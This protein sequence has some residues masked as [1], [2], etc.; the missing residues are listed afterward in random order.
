V[1]SFRSPFAFLLTAVAALAAAAPAP[2]DWLVTKDGA[3]IETKGA[4]K[5]QGRQVVFTM[6][7]GTLSAL[8]AE[9]VDLDRSA[10]VTAQAAEAAV[11]VEEPAPEVARRAPVMTL[12]ERDIPPSA[13]PEMPADFAP[14]A[15]AGGEAGEAGEAGEE[16]AAESAP[17]TSSDLE[18]LSWDKAPTTSGDGLQI[19]GTLKNSGNSTITS[20][21][22][23]VMVYD[24][25]GRLLATAEGTVNSGVIQ[26]GR[27]ANFRVALPGVTD[28]VGIKF[29]AQGRGFRNSQAE[30]EAAEE[31][32]AP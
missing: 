5:V 9:E 32:A 22:L 1:N 14:E 8:R 29:D 19:A 20:P 11:R 10:V 28:F 30:G 26:A 6:P 2:A 25:D 3:R 17:E 27:T 21:S 18:V 13:N 15:E 24:E 4:W 7:N 23:M 12:T 16:G 31:S